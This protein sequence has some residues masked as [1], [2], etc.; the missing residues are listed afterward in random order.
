M[1]NGV[2]LLAAVLAGCLQAT[3]YVCQDGSTSDSPSSCAVT[4]PTTAIT[5]QSAADPVC[6][7]FK[8]SD[9]Q[10]DTQLIR[11]CQLHKNPT[12]DYCLQLPEE[13]GFGRTGCLTELAAM[14][15][16]TKPCET[17]EGNTKILCEASASKDVRACGR[18]P[19]PEFRENCNNTV[20]RLTPVVS[21]PINCSGRSGDD[22]TWCVV[23]G[24]AAPDDCLQIDETK[25][26]DEA[27][28]CRA[29]IA[30]NMS[31]CGGIGDT[32]MRNLCLRTVSG[33]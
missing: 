27:A 15:N 20:M 33:I 2:I 29:R 3:V 16:D 12:I 26:H 8:T 23:Y 1:K 25:Y 28:F 5:A 22:L 19:L 9:G 7:A 30:G 11:R 31:G 18:I 32:V 14:L 24:A 10:S 21:Q 13:T 4:A 6:S 17:L